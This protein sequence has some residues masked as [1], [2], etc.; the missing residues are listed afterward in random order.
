M[1]VGIEDGGG[2]KKVDVVTVV[3][4]NGL[5]FRLRETPHLGFSLSVNP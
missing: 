4:I 2:S 1:P 5:E 3:I